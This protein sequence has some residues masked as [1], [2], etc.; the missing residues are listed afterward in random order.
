[1]QHVAL[2]IMSAI[3]IFAGV[4]HFLKPNVYLK[5]MPPMLPYPLSLV[6]IS[7]IFEIVCGVLLLFPATRS[8]AAWLTI[9]LLIAILPANIQ[10]AVNFKR[11]EHPYFWVTILRLP[12]QFVLI[13]WAWLYT[14]S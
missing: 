3:Y 6:Y 9:L 13:W 8:F 7:G 10:M 1:M 4:M 14:R 12:L 5:M 11:I 2:Y